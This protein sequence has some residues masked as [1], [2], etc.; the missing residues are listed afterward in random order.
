MIWRAGEVAFL[1]ES[2][3]AQGEAIIR[4]YRPDNERS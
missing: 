3:A 2:E 4:G 1:P